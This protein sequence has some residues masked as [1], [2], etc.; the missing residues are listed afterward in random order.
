MEV[1]LM[2]LGVGVWKSVFNGYDIPDSL[3]TDLHGRRLYE[4]NSKVVDALLARLTKSKFIKVMHC[5]FA[6]QIWDKLQNVYEGD[7]K[8]K[9]AKIQTQRG[10]FKSMKMREEED[11][12][13]YFLQVDE[14][15]NTIK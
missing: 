11:V 6:K 14:I 3:P 2:D 15:V 12:V 1:H 9:Q 5:R 10:K 7:E 13:A 8:V 4:N